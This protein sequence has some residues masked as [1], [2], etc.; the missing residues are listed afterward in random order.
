MVTAIR[1]RTSDDPFM[2]DMDNIDS[3]TGY[4][5]NIHTNSCNTNQVNYAGGASA[6]RYTKNWNDRIY[7]NKTHSNAND[8]VNQSLKVTGVIS[9]FM[10]FCPNCTLKIESATFV[11]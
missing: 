2:S 11:L 3:S 5:Q 6:L 9:C 10:Q 1:T 8:R 4:G 7:T